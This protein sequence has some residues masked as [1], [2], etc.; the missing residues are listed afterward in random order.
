MYI[1]QDFA[2]YLGEDAKTVPAIELFVKW[3]KKVDPHATFAVES[4]F[5]WTSAELFADALKQAG[6]P[7]T[8]A[9]LIA[10]LKK[11]ILFNSGGLIPPSHPAQNIPTNCFVLAQVQ[12]GQ[13]KRVSPTPATGFDCPARGLPAGSR[14]QTDGT[15]D[16]VRGSMPTLRPTDP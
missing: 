10:A 1:Y 9:G 16:V 4:I 3:M 5:G 8:R 12:N 15:A 13:I 14:I 2:L 7:P 11:V 6:N